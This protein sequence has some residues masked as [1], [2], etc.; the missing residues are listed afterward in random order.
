MRKYK[1]ILIFTLAVL[2]CFCF[3]GC[4]KSQK[5]DVLEFTSVQTQK[6]ETAKNK[7]LY[8][9]NTPV[10]KLK[11]LTSSSACTMYIDPDTFAVAI[12]DS[13][14]GKVWRSL[15]EKYSGG[16][17]AVLSVNVI[18]D[19]ESFTFNSQT[20]SVNKKT[21]EYKKTKTGLVVT[22]GFKKELNSG[23]TVEL[24][25]PVEYTLDS[26]SM[27]VSVD[28]SNLKSKKSEGNT[29]ITSISLLEYFGSG[30]GDYIVIPDGCGAII[31]LK[32]KTE[33]FSAIDLPVYGGDPA[34]GE[35]TN[36]ICPVAAFGMKTGKSAFAALIES[37]DAVAH[38]TANKIADGKGYNKVG[39]RFDLAKTKS[40]S[41]SKTVYVQKNGYNGQ[42]KLTYRF[43]SRENSDYIDIANACRE[44]LVRNGTLNFGSASKE[45]NVPFV[46]SVMQSAYLG[47]D[48]PKKTTL[49]T[50]EQTNEII[51]YLRA[52]G[53]SGIYLN[54]KGI[55]NGGVQKSSAGST[56][57]NSKLGTQNELSE[58]LK[59]ADGQGVQVFA[60]TNLLSANNEKAK[61]K[62]AAINSTLAQ[63][64]QEPAKGFSTIESPLLNFSSI[65]KTVNELLLDIRELPIDGISL[66]DAGK[67]LY[68]DFSKKGGKNRSAVKDTIA[69]QCDALSSGHALMVSASNIYALKSADMVIDIPTDA[70]CSKRNDCTAIPFLQTILHGLVPYA[71]KPINLEKDGDTAMLKNAEYGC[72]AQYELYYSD[73]DKTQGTDNYYYINQASH[74]AKVAEKLSKLFTGLSDKRI[75]AHRQIQ[76]GVYCTQYEGSVNIY[77]NYN[78]KAVT[79][80]GITIEEMDALRVN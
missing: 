14:G 67:V 12:L 7:G 77:V 17:P 46:L 51:S 73:L 79:V 24:S 5:A 55:F 75:T 50:F 21:V 62:A 16:T 30:S 25:V 18:A 23:K 45:N 80:D 69:A 1:I 52:K 31:D 57:L 27:S 63:Y 32:K 38:I 76:K 40:D 34:A 39:A 68:T 74:A 11:K 37:G 2:M 26:T 72:A 43:L 9:S 53:I 19:G 71:S 60:E 41:E 22:Y 61:N 8:V 47:N 3:F 42:I 56:K 28:C 70:D 59:Y 66:G 33:K 48:K 44:M 36:T 78:K 20:D 64:S 10:K 15:P 6:S 54:C 4:S 49:S 13:I 35:K 58:L 29:I 65:E